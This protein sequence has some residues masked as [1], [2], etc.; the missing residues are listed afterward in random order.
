VFETFYHPYAR[1]FLR[2]LEIGGV[3]QLMARTLQV[4]PQAVRGWTPSFDFNALYNPQPPVVKPYPGA[5][6]ASDPG[7]TGLDFAPGSAGAYS[8]NN[9]EVF[10]QVPMFMA[11]LLL[12]NKQF[13]DALT[14]LEYI[15]NP[16]DNS[17]GPSPQRFWQMAPFNAMNSA[18]WLS[19]QIENLLSTLA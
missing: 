11:S 3:P 8:L 9:W 6:G 7:E 16:S 4:N 1:T 15:F 2:E 5:A 19:Q 18:V 10:Y 13:Q 17:G 12:Q 14:W